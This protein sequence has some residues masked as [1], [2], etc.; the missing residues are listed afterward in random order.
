VP[1]KINGTWEQICTFEALHRAW[2]EVKRGKAERGLVL[3]Y[4]DDLVPNLERVLESLRSGTYHPQPHYEFVLHD[5]KERLIQAPHLEDRIVQHA[6]CNAIRLP[7][8]NKLIHHTYSCLIGRGVH[9]CSQQLHKYLKSGK[10]SYYVKADVRKF[11][12]SID[13]ETLMAEVRRVFKCRRTIDLLELFVRV[14]NQSGCGI[15]IGASTSQILA[16]LALNPLDHY[17]RRELKLNTYLRYCDDM[18]VLFETRREAEDG[19]DGIRECLNRLKFTLNTSSHTGKVSSGID[20]VGYRHLPGYR[21]I[22]K[23][24]IRRIKNRL[25]LDHDALA[26]Y[27]SHAKGTA[28]LSYVSRLCSKCRGTTVSRWLSRNSVE[29]K[30]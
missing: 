18:V 11:F 12:Y 16:N 15:P 22:R 8:Q 23:S 17:V 5:N 30:V 19:L 21:L 27:L 7:V 14:N 25:P 4:E 2:R 9:R 6:V 3:R 13:H 1:Q 28:S 10:Y 20:W 26:S 24:T 29:S